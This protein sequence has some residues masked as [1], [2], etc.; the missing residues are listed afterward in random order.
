LG[1][2][3]SNGFGLHCLHLD[4]CQQLT[5]AQ[6][7]IEKT[8][9][10]F[11]QINHFSKKK[12]KKMGNQT[13]GCIEHIAFPVPMP[14]YDINHEHFFFVKDVPCMM[15]KTS[16]KNVILYSHGNSYDIGNAHDLL[17]HLSKELNVNII[18]Y[19]YPGYGVLYDPKL[20]TSSELGCIE[21]INKVFQFLIT[22]G[23]LEKNII[24]YGVS[25]GTGPTV[26]IASR[27][28]NLKGVLLQSP[29]T[30]SIG[31]ASEQ[32]ECISDSICSRKHNPN[33]F[34]N[35]DKID[36]ITAPIIILHGIQDTLIP[37]S[38]SEV[39]VKKN[40]KIKLVKI[41]NGTHNNIKY[42]VIFKYLNEL[43][44]Y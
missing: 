31:I 37:I 38:H 17:Q 43:L 8:N 11:S 3:K 21:S 19:D 6:Y 33:I 41:E 4:F 18:S 44:H 28:H 34:R 30:S 2:K 36:L 32:M 29:F 1:T 25:I 16:S 23:F 24:L 14:S 10:F 7:V 27:V 42:D 40:P 39:L 9:I 22:E 5:L 26:D 12:L 20:R 13:R 15:Y 35:S